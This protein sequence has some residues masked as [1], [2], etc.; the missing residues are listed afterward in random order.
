M[1]VTALFYNKALLDKAGLQP[2][3]TLADMKAMVQPLKAVGAVPLVHPAGDI[4]W[5]PRHR[6]RCSRCCSG[7]LSKD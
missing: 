3:R 5:N 4:G 2:P 6:W 1:H 7:A